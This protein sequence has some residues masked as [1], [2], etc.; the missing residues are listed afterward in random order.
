MILEKIDECF[1]CKKKEKLKYC[2]K[3]MIATYCSKKCQKKDWKKIHKNNCMEYNKNVMKKLQVY[4]ERKTDF[5]SKIS[6]NN[7]ILTITSTSHMVEND[8]DKYIS[9]NVLFTNFDLWNKAK[10]NID[11]LKLDCFIL[12]IEDKKKL[13]NIG[14]EIIDFCD[15]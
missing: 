12:S 6:Y 1:R 11:K 5:I 15:F 14:I 10:S 3:C 8:F 9:S 2:K 4:L 7:N 13:N